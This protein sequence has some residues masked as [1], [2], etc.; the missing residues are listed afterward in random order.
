[1]YIH[2]TMAGSFKCFGRPPKTPNKDEVFK[3]LSAYHH[4]FQDHWMNY[5]KYEKSR[6]LETRKAATKIVVTMIRS[7]EADGP[8]SE[9][10]ISRLS[11]LA[12]D[13]E[14][15]LTRFGNEVSKVRLVKGGPK[16]GE[17]EALLG[18]MSFLAQAA[19]DTKK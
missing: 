4:E 19:R 12:T 16:P 15:S 11:P 18:I 2:S 8:T 6:D 17:A 7:T 5:K 14:K 1:M 10:D 3:L 9:A 13:F